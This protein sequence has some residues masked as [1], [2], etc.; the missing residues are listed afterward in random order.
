M[1]EVAPFSMTSGKA[2]GGIGALLLRLWETRPSEVSESRFSL[3][4]SL[5]L[6]PEAAAA[7]AASARASKGAVRDDF[8]SVSSGVFKLG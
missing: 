2:L 3:S 5:V 1:V 7:A 6:L 8:G 4:S